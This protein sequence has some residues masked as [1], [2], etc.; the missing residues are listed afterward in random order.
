MKEYRKVK[1][2]E[3]KKLKKNKTQN[4]DNRKDC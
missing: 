4:R 2:A 1:Q 3:K